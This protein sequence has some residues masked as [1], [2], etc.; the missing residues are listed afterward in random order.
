MAFLVIRV[1]LFSWQVL[2]LSGVVLVGVLVCVAV[3]CVLI[4]GVVGGVAITRNDVVQLLILVLMWCERCY[5]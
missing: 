3:V 2:L 4:V 5:C 1:G